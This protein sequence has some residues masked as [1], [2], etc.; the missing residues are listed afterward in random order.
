MDAKKWVAEKISEWAFF[1]LIGLGWA[2]VLAWLKLDHSAL[3]APLLYGSAGACMVW[4]AGGLYI[5]ISRIPRLRTRVT[6]DNI[7]QNVRAWLDQSGFSVKSD[8]V[9]ETFFRLSAQAPGGC[10][11]S[12][13][14]PRSGLIDHVLIHAPIANEKTVL[15]EMQDA[16]KDEQTRLLELVKVELARAR[17]GYFGLSFPL[18]QQF[19]VGRSVRITDSLNEEAFIRAVWD[20]E[21]A[22]SAVMA[23]YRLWIRE[24][25]KVPVQAT[26]TTPV[27]QAIPSDPTHDP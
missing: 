5:A 13:G 27:N 18:S 22:V 9:P 21:A 6:V 26:N 10:I 8:T 7:E 1:G 20:V 2:A 19:S 25:G 15:K 4:V 23:V 16:P 12:I 3:A 17:V 11:F 24:V 14:R